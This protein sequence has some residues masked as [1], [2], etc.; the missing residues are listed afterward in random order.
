MDRLSELIENLE[1]ELREMQGICSVDVAQLRMEC[2]KRK[3]KSEF[4]K[5]SK[6]KMFFALFEPIFNLLEN[7]K[8]VIA[9]LK[10][11][12]ISVSTQTSSLKRKP[13][14]LH[15]F[16]IKTTAHYLE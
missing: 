4:Y 2:Q 9:N 13:E 12:T 15:S 3:V 7:I 16:S 11:T 10:T 8:T 14:N 6:E 1:H 5:G